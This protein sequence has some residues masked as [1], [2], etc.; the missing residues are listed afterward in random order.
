MSKARNM[1]CT[2]CKHEVAAELTPISKWS[3]VSFALGS[4]GLIPLVTYIRQKRGV[5]T[6]YWGKV[7]VCPICKTELGLFKDD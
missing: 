1:F 3:K 2:K 7:R 4:F 6:L 5:N